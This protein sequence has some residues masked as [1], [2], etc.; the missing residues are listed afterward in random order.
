MERLGD[1]DT[2]KYRCLYE[3]FYQICYQI[4]EEKIHFLINGGNVQRTK[5]DMKDFLF[6]QRCRSWIDALQLLVCAHYPVQL[7][8]SNLYL[9]PLCLCR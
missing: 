1:T 5:T 3:H 8:Y 2:A 7:L 6:C 4:Q 9:R